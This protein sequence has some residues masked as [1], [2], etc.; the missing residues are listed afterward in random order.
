MSDNTIKKAAAKP[1]ARFRKYILPLIGLFCIYATSGWFYMISLQEDDLLK[2]QGRI[3]GIRQEKVRS[4]KS[5]SYP[6]I[7]AIEGEEFTIRDQYQHLMPAISTKALPGDNVTV[8]YRTGKQ[9]AL[10]M[11]DQHDIF[12]LAK[13][14]DKLFL[15]EETRA[16]YRSLTPYGIGATVL[17]WGAYLL[18]FLRAKRKKRYSTDWINRGE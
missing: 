15:L 10:G 3:T 2:K 11:G 18:L 4:G 13:G 12:Q 1:S 8:Y 17:I 16:H 5:Y 6:L 9:T 7:I 14:D